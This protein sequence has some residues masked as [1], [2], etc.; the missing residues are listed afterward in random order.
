MGE[1][2]GRPRTRRLAAYAGLA[3]LVLLGSACAVGRLRAPSREQVLQRILPASAQ[4]VLERNG[5][6]VRSGSGVVIAVR[7]S[8]EATEC[9]V[10]TSG[11]TL[12][13]VSEPHEVY[14]LLGRQRG[15]GSRTSATILARRESE[16]LDL[17]LL[18]IRS[19]RCVAARLGQPPALGD[20]IWVVAYPWGRAMTLASGIVSQVNPDV[21]GD[22]E[23]ASRLMV[24]A[25]VSYGASGGGVFE[26][27]TGRLVGLVEGYRTA[28]VS[29]K[30]EAA[31]RYID[32]P[33]PGETYV[34]PLTHIRRFLA[35]SGH[36]DLLEEDAP[37]ARPQ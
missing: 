9:F 30:G 8:E 31:L 33:V 23:T 3:M 17:A 4:I 34:T 11:H 36:A 12:A 19:D 37:V 27:E 2:T 32:V 14:V 5:R 15:R 7:P 6:R 29:Y 25:S 21:P 28:R 22:Q 26:V 1:A 20:A 13:G 18:R 10:L 16:E 24:D 35:E